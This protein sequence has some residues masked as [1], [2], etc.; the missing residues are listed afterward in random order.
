MNGKNW[1][2]HDLEIS[3]WIDNLEIKE[4][5]KKSIQNSKLIGDLLLPRFSFSTIIA[6]L[7][8]F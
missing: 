5:G 8:R 7:V 1:P 2:V 3:I 4:I 6:V